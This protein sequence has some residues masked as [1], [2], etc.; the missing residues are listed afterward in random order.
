MMM[1]AWPV[2]HTHQDLPLTYTYAFILGG[3]GGTE[4]ALLTKSFLT[5]VTGITMPQVG[6]DGTMKR[7]SVYIMTV[8]GYTVTS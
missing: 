4:V 7:K 1:T 2:C 5:A 3:D 6:D 8:H